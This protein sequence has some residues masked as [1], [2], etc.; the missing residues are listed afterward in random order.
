M[1]DAQDIPELADE[2]R[3]ADASCYSRRVFMKGSLGLLAAGCIVGGFVGSALAGC[4]SP[5]A[6]IATPT[7]APTPLVPLGH[8][9]ARNAAR[10]TPLVTLRPQDG[11]ARAV[12]WAPDSRIV[13]SGG[14]HD[15]CLW[16]IATGALRARLTGHTNQIYSMA[17]SATSGLAWSPDGMRLASASD[18]ETVCLW[19]VR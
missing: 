2:A 3:P 4:A 6:T 5:D 19:G 17:W 10:I 1:M 11:L 12:A 7:I 9:T 14:Y 18:D 16:D 15:V 13:A 8:I